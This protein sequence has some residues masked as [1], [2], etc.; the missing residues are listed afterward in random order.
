M[1]GLTLG[2]QD[3]TAVR[4]EQIAA[5][6]LGVFAILIFT[7]I[8]IYLCGRHRGFKEAAQRAIHGIPDLHQSRSRLHGELPHSP[9]PLSQS[10]GRGRFI[11]LKKTFGIKTNT[12]EASSS[13]AQKQT[14]SHTSRIRTT[15]PLQ[16]GIHP[17]TSNPYSGSEEFQAAVHNL[18]GYRPEDVAEW[19][20]ESDDDAHEDLQQR[21]QQEPFSA[22][23]QCTSPLPAYEE[24]EPRRFSWQ[25]QESDYRP[26]KR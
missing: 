7:S 6:S 1:A 18:L 10:T 3:T 8:C 22:I 15:L 14:G 23:D 12:E 9:A 25:G 5:L 13:S 16:I 26:E 17:G 21:H 4:P 11:K 20:P 19:Y 2:M 24:L